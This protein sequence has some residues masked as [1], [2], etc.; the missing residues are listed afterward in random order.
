MV[1]GVASARGEP[2]IARLLFVVLGPPVAWSGH[3]GVIYFLVAAICAA[4]GAGVLVPVGAATV[5]AAGVSAWAG[6]MARRLWKRRTEG[7][8]G[9]AVRL[10]LAIGMLGSAFFTAAIL[11]EA[12][13]P[14]FL[15]PCPPGEG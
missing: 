5:V 6:V 8:E 9:G 12:L 1:T 15:P 14:L 10:F 7:V 2:S 11:L 3:F 4:G 13:P